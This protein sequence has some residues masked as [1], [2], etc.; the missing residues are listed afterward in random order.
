MCRTFFVN[1]L[2][3]DQKRIYYCFNNLTTQ[4]LGIPLPRRKGKHIKRFTPSEKLEEI[5]KHI[6]FF[7]TLDSHYYRATTVKKY[8]APD[9]TIT[10]MYQYYLEDTP[11][12]LK[13]RVYRKVFN[14]EFNLSFYTPKKDQCNKCF[15][16]KNTNNPTADEKVIY[17]KHVSEKAISKCERD[18]D[19]SN[20]DRNHCIVCYDLQNIF[21]LPKGNAAA[22]FYKRRLNTYNLTGTV[23]LPGK[24][25]I[26]YCAI[27]TEV[28]SG[29]TGNDIASALVKILTCLCK[30]NPNI[31]RI[32][33]WSDSCIPQNR[34][35]INSTAIK[36]FFKLFRKQHFRNRA[37]VFGTRT[38]I[39]TGSRLCT[40]RY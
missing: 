17:E 23:I 6:N 31:T 12:P 40:L 29:R 7:P 4:D 24:E 3:I 15:L 20:I 13:L 27:W 36:Y 37:K 33:L 28:H 25:K 19:R 38:F 11:D 1:K 10:K 34:N 32:T 18:L 21:A 8:L 39:N 26:T 35:Q 2:G 30:E 16:Y 22:F 14:N 9:L 5:R